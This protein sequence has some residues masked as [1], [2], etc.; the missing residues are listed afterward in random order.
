[1]PECAA[2]KPD[3][4]V[5]LSLV[6][7][8]AWSLGSPVFLVAM[9]SL[10]DANTLNKPISAS[11]IHAIISHQGCEQSQRLPWRWSYR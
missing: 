1:M 6:N 4:F 9:K 11:R 10:T 7:V 3:Q 2:L 5:P 8:P